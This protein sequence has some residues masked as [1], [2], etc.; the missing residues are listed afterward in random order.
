[1]KQEKKDKIIEI[2]KTGELI[3]RFWKGTNRSG[4]ISHSLKGINRLTETEVKELRAEGIVE[5]DKDGYKGGG[6]Y[7]YKL[8]I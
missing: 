4:Y 5:A 3:H 2:M 7:N 1:M 8:K 6:F